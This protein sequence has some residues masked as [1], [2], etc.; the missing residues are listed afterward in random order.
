MIPH[1]LLAAQ[2][3]IAS[4]GSTSL[5]VEALRGIAYFRRGAWAAFTHAGECIGQ[6][7]TSREAF[8]ALGG[9]A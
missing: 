1:T 7:A 6:F 9:A 8:A 2:R 4:D 5:V 3:V